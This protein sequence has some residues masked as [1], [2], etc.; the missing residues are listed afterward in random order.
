MSLPE[1][2][3][4]AY[5]LIL[6]IINTMLMAGGETFDE[7]LGEVSRLNSMGAMSKGKKYVADK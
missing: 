2:K 1:T 6:G 3:E 7:I 4:Q 5:L